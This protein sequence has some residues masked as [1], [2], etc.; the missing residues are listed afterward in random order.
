MSKWI[1]MKSIV[2]LI[3]CW[4]LDY[5][6]KIESFWSKKQGILVCADDQLRGSTIENAQN[7]IHYSMPHDNFRKFLFRY[8]AMLKFFEDEMSGVSCEI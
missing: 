6:K 5:S 7:I 4:I 1:E 2:E 8:S 3:K